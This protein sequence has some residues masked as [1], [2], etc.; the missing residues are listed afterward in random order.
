M[1]D[2]QIG[3]YIWHGLCCGK[4]VQGNGYDFYRRLE[5]CL[6]EFEFEAF[7]AAASWGE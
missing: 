1:D 6:A 3:F 7:E 2:R 5:Q 4:Y